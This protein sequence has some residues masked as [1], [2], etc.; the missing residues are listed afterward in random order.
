MDK[1]KQIEEMTELMA[2]WALRNNMC[3][4]EG[5][6]KALAETFVENDYGKIPENVVVPINEKVELDEDEGEVRVLN[7]TRQVYDALIALARKETAEKFAERL[8]ENAY[9]LK[10]VTGLADTLV[11]DWISI[12][13]IAKEFTEG[14]H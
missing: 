10:D 12:D 6:A 9:N 5:H 11:V 3:W 13:E 14:K 2:D 7:M 8:K 4:H 1:Q